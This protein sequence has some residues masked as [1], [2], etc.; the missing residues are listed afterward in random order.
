MDIQ[1]N[2]ASNVKSGLICAKFAAKLQA[3]HACIYW[4]LVLLNVVE[5]KTMEII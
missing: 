5:I 3:I 4:G 1:Y 2:R